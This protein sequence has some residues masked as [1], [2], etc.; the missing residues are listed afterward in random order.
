[1]LEVIVKGL[2]EKRQTDRQEERKGGR[3]GDW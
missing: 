3:E 1:M 2:D